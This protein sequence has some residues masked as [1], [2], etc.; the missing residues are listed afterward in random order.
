MEIYLIV[1]MLTV[2][3]SFKSLRSSVTPEGTAT[4]E[5][6][7]VAH[8]F[9]DLLADDAPLEPEKVQVVAR[10]SSLGAWVTVGGGTA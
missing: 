9:C 3:P 2:V 10:S 5:S 1:S 8:D 6:T 7:M 4:F